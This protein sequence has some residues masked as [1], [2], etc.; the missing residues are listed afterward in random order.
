MSKF[1]TKENLT[2]IA[3][4]I[5]K[6]LQR[7]LTKD[8]VANLFHMVK[9]AYNLPKYSNLSVGAFNLL[10]LNNY[11]G[12]PVSHKD[13]TDIVDIHS[14]LVDNIGIDG[15]EPD[16]DIVSNVD[17][18]A[19][20][21]NANIVE[22]IDTL[23][24][25]GNIKNVEKI[26]T[27]GN[28]VSFLGNSD[29][30]S[31]LKTTNPKAAYRTSYICLDSRYRD[32]SQDVSTTTFSNI[33]WNFLNTTN[34][35][36][37]AVNYIGDVQEVVSISTGDIRIPY[38]VSNTTNKYNRISMLVNEW[39][40][41][42]FI[43]NEGR[44]FHLMFA[45]KTDD[46]MLDC[47]ALPNGIT[48]FNFTKPITQLDTITISF[49]SPLE[50]LLFDMD[51]M[52]MQVLYQNPMQLTSVLPHNLQTGDPIYISG[53]STNSS[54][55]N[56]MVARVNLSSGYNIRYIDDNTIQIDDI[57]LTALVGAINGLYVSV[58]FG[59]KRIIVPLTITYISK[60][61]S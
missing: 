58:Y 18:N 37:G 42:S 23:N 47:S 53:F 39:S 2:E 27:V 4:T 55:D 59:S 57:D 7:K 10:M 41:Q 40:G 33:G 16:L 12:K 45:S 29:M 25:I 28:V 56:V 54:S 26:N 32:I 20:A 38:R 11:I 46:N 1:F 5:N 49:G 44:K 60:N 48:T 15:Q 22:H 6:Q 35:T 50:S 8:E 17:S 51:R 36:N 9:N 3:N 13:D 30:I 52:Q 21:A 61:S 31:F 19:K 14:F 24:T 34:A 43:A